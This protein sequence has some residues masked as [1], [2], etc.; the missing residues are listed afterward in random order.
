MRLRNAVERLAALPRM[1]VGGNIAGITA[2]PS[3]TS[4]P[5]GIHLQG[6][7][8]H[9]CQMQSQKL[10][11]FD[12]S[13]ATSM[14]LMAMHSQHCQFFG[15]MGVT[16]PPPDG[17]YAEHQPTLQH[18]M[19][20]WIGAKLQQPSEHGIVQASLSSKEIGGDLAAV[21]AAKLMIRRCLECSVQGN[22]KQKDACQEVAKE[23]H[24]QK[25]ACQEDAC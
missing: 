4:P 19:M 18:L 12:T 10:L 25:D 8:N 11:P 24:Q 17:L 3:L 6:C 15:Q 21:Y 9:P 5:P 1:E 14:C 23:G 20:Q 2:P 7:V 13:L 22:H 16:L